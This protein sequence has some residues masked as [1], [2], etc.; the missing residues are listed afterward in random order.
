MSDAQQSSVDLVLAYIAASQRARATQDPGDFELLRTYLAEDLIIKQA[1]PWTDDP[2]RIVLNSADALIGR[3]RAP[4]NAGSVLHTETVNAVAAG[5][6]VLVEQVSTI[7]TAAQRHVSS[8][9]F[10][11]SVS[12]GKITGGRFYR[13]DAGLPIG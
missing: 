5:A 9:C 2:W 1:G 8:V 12:D 7:T 3:L 13:N 11:F 6:D 4:A 10:L